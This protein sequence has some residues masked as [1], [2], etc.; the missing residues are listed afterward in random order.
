MG[1]TRIA[2]AAA[3]A[4]IALPA[5]AQEPASTELG[6]VLVSPRRIPG[7][8]LRLSRVPGSATIV[9]EEM[10]RETKASTVQEVLSRVE[11]VTFSDQQ[12]F[13]LGSDST[14]NMRGIVNSSRTN[15]LVLVD[16]IRQNRLTGD[17]VH[18]Q[19]IPAAQIERIE[20]LR[21]GSATIY[22]E[23]ALAG[24]INIIT[25]KDSEKLLET[26]TGAEA[27]SFGWQQY[28][29]AARGR[30]IP[31]SYSM[32]ATRSLVEGYRE[33]SQS[34]N[35]TVGA[36]F[37]ADVLPSLRTELH[38]RHH[39]DTTGFPGLLTL[40]QSQQRQQQTNSFHGINNNEDDQV[41]LDIIGGPWDGLSTLLTVYWKRRVQL[42]EDSINFNPF[43]VTPS[44]GINLRTDYEWTGAS[45]QNLFVQGLELSRDKATTGDPGV[46][47]D[48]ESNRSAYGVYLEDT[49]T[50]RD[51][52]SLVAGLRFDKSRYEE[53][54][55]FPVFD[56]TLRFEGWSPKL[57]VIVNAVPE[58]LDVFVSYARP[59][60]APNV[61]DFSSRLG[62]SFSGNAD[63]EPQQ[64]DTYELGLR[65]DRS[66]AT[67][68][69]TAF[70][71]RIDDEIL[72]NSLATP[73][74]TNQ[75]FNTRRFGVEFS[76]RWMWAER[77]RGS[78]T[79]TFVDAEFRKGT[80]AGLTIPG[81]P[82]HI[83]NASLGV[84]P[85]PGLWM[86]LHWQLVQDYLRVN[87]MSNTLGGAD[88]Y[89]VLDLICQYDVPEPSAGFSWADW[90][91]YLKVLNLTNEEYVTY[92]SSNGTN[93]N[94][95]G[96]APMPPTT[97]IAGV[98]VAF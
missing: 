30:R 92:Q 28:R 37:G 75:N 81:T 66:P 11:G 27:G 20:I 41:S 25:K 83:L 95:A 4:F 21:G 89:G 49:L 33:F 17:D 56:G 22:G 51:R 39:E 84:S 2:I 18:W 52:V 5:W 3:L 55:T 24:V 65:L 67:F 48:S 58:M 44:H 76:S 96:E 9:T 29:V 40:A 64:A 43:T 36:H 8:G 38:V 19:A 88:N 12:G 54:L 90:S 16:G 10:I 7:Y 94:G 70:Y 98:D 32:D 50:I 6:S 35:T 63:L 61:D 34:R 42:S 46:G 14:V 93:L 72:L 59:F 74:Q 60:K 79:Y 78:A 45:V 47:A 62:S 97:F 57:G 86:D 80:F 85:W 68:S 91:A 15:A 71:T 87:D 53:S 31:F 82:E 13:G 1:I 26:E 77:L 69:A 73:F 23:G